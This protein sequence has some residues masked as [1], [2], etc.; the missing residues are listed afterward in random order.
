MKEFTWASSFGN[1][2]IYLSV[3]KKWFSVFKKWFSFIFFFNKSNIKHKYIILDWVWVWGKVK[4]IDEKKERKKWN[5]MEGVK[6]QT[7]RN[8]RKTNIN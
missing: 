4:E 3:F 5:G 6:T 7:W 2:V 8:V 1:E